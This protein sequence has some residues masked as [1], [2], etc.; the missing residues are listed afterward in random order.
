MKEKYKYVG[1]IDWNCELVDYLTIG[2]IYEF[3]MEGDD[4]GTTYGKNGEEVFE[5]FPE[6]AHGKWEKIE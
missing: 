2:N 4:Y 5:F 1:N 3:E 6:P